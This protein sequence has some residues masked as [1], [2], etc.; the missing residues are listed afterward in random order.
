MSPYLLAGGINPPKSPQLRSEIGRLSQIEHVQ[1]TPVDIEKV[2]DTTT[3][4]NAFAT[5]LGPTR[6]VTIYDTLLDSRFT[7]GE[8]RFVIAHEFGHIWHNHLYKGIGWSVIFGLP[9]ALVLAWVT[10]RR[11]GLGD[12]GVLPYGV[13]VLMLLNIVV[14]PIG[15]VVSRRDEAEADWSALRAT[16]DPSSGRTLFK[17]F[18]TTSLQEPNPPT[19]AYLWLETHPTLMQRIAMTQAWQTRQSPRMP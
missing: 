15:N 10:R 1:G 2:S 6:R 12:P 14:T 3:E 13:L 5:G 9:I 11:G 17:K 18:S 8:V 19:W 16:D 7:S 4:P